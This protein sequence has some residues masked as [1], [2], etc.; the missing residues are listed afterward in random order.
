MI[1]VIG[2]NKGGVGKT[3]LATNLAIAFA[4]QMKKVLLV[5]A[6]P[7]GSALYW[8]SVRLQKQ[9]SPFVSIVQ[10]RGNLVDSLKVL[11]QQNQ[12][13]IV[14]VPGRNSPELISAMSVAN[15]VVSPH[16]CSQLD[17]ETLQEL[18]DQILALRTLNP[19]LRVL[20][21]QSMATTNPAIR[22]RERNDFCRYVSAF[23]Y[24]RLANPMGFQRLVY[25]ECISEGTGVLESNNTLA[26]EEI[27]LLL[28][29]I[30][31]G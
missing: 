14:D 10:R 11:S 22:Q 20:I 28:E 5:D 2:S 31:N 24:F 6:D 4:L 15:V 16:A 26:A 3:T 1:I 25:R 29:E 17:L 12:I 23:E 9:L 19:G 7:Q 8:G 13:V 18:E 27:Q 21:Y 30:L